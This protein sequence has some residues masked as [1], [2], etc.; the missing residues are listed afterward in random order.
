M[1]VPIVLFLVVFGIFYVFLT[2]RHREKM[3]MMENNL[4][5]DKYSMQIFRNAH[6]ALKHGMLFIGISLGIWGGYILEHSFGMG[7]EFAY[8]SMI[9]F[10]AG[11]SLIIYYFIEKNNL[12][13]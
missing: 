1:I 8:P 10:F 12:R 11:L 4:D 5:P 7:N 9:F 13:D 3:Y 2:Q 6:E